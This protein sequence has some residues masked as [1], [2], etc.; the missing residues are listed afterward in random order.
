MLAGLL[1][2]DMT[3]AATLALLGA[4]FGTSF[5]TAAFGIGGGA[6]LIAILASVLP[7]AVLIP[8][9]GVV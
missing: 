3:L 7:P 9:H 6:L 5:V 8:I 1:P 4:S 2:P